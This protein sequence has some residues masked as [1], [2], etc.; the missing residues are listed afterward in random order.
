[1]TRAVDKDRRAFPGCLRAELLAWIATVAEAVSDRDDAI[2]T[3]HGFPLSED[4]PSVAIREIRPQL[5]EAAIAYAH[6]ADPHV[7]ETA[8]AACIPLLDD[9]RLLHYRGTLVPLLQKVLGKSELWQHRERAIDA[10][11]A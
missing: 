3:R 4:P 11:D 10:L 7:R 1:M 6:D 2:S 9:P 8:I 5:Y